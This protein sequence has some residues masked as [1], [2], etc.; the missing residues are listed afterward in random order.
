MPVTRNYYPS[1]VR[2]GVLCQ[3]VVQLERPT[4]RLVLS[5]DWCVGSRDRGET[6]PGFEASTDERGG[7]GRGLDIE[8][9]GYV[10]EE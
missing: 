7:L 1:R 2:I 8:F 4:E 5:G 9:G 3:S 6:I 10:V